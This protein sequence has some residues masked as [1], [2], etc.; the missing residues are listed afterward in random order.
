[1]SLAVFSQETDVVVVQNG[2]H[3][4]GEVKSLQNNVLSF[5]TDDMGTLR[6]KWDRVLHIIS[7]N[8]FRVE[9]KNGTIIFG[10]LDSTEINEFVRVVADSNWT[11]VKSE[12]VV[13]ILR[14]N[15]T[16]L[17]RIDGEVGMGYSFTKSSAVHSVNAKFNISYL[18]NK[19]LS[20]FRSNGIFTNQQDSI[21]TSK[22]DLVLSQT[23][24]LKEHMFMTL[25][26]ALQQ[27]SELGIERR[28]L[29]SVTYGKNF[30]KRNRMLFL[31]STG[32]AG[33]NETYFAKENGEQDADVVDLE[34]VFKLEFRSFSNNEPEFNIHPYIILYPS[35]TNW[36]RV[37]SDF[38]V[39]LSF[40]IINDLMFTLTYYNQFD[41]Q[42]PSGA[43]ESDFGVV[44]SFNYTF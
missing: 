44:T 15:Q 11:E 39:D 3:I 4:T 40:E 14:I 25:S 16:I 30:I 43:T 10:S 41:N 6:I 20:E 9:L 29:G 21:V 8:N 5:K 1:M 18:A 32:L 28:S 34:A 35:L 12:E 19:N 33:N 36:G 2:D 37:R 7:K 38:N 31:I 22:A 13:D 42:P 17:G 27:N 24:L 23:R 26:W